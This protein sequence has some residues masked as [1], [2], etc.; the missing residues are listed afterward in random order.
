LGTIAADVVD[1]LGTHPDADH[2]QKS[3]LLKQVP[4]GQWALPGG[5]WSELSVHCANR[6]EVP[7]EPRFMNRLSINVMSPTAR[8]LFR[9]P[10]GRGLA[11]LK[12]GGE[13]LAYGRC[14][15]GQCERAKPCEGGVCS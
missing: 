6:V 5:W 11:W 13:V 10:D 3:E 12:S 14:E 9:S 1:W 15:Q 7:V 4:H 8:C 2:K